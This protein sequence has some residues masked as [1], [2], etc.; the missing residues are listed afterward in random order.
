[1]PQKL[2]DAIN[3]YQTLRFKGY[4]FD[5]TYSKKGKIIYDTSFLIR[6]EKENFRHLILGTKHLK[7]DQFIEKN[8]KKLFDEFS[9]LTITNYS[10]S[11]N[12]NLITS[13]PNYSTIIDRL[14]NIKNLDS[15]L[16]NKNIQVFQKS[17]SP[18]VLPTSIKFDFL[19]KLDKYSNNTDTPFLF[20]ER[21]NDNSVVCNPVST[22]RSDKPYEQNHKSKQVIT[23]DTT[24]QVY[25]K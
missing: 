9:S 1:M 3:A 10:T 23:L 2:L 13:D 11:K 18:H 17:Q 22:F 8:S 4:F 21:T 12:F 5:L 16:T 19:L 6:F 14:E 24:T 20:I 15:L 7:N 25:K